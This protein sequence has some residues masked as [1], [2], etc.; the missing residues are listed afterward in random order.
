MRGGGGGQNTLLMHV[1]LLLNNTIELLF[2]AESHR[3]NF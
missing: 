1:A 2:H 3:L